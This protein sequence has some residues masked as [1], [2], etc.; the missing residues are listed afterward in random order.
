[1]MRR[2]PAAKLAHCMRNALLALQHRDFVV[3]ACA[4]FCTTLAW[5][6]LSVAVGWQVYR[7]TRNPLDLGLVGLAQFLPFA[8]LVLPAGYVVD[9]RDRRAVLIGAYVMQSLAAGLLLAFS[10]GD[11]RTVTPI[12][13][14]MAL[15]GVARAFS[16]PAAQ[17]VT[18]NLVPAEVFPS[19][20]AC[21]AMLFEV[22]V[23]VGPSLGGVLFLLG[24]PVVYALGFALVVLVGV[25]LA[26]IRPVRPLSPGRVV[27]PSS[28]MEGV[29]FV[30]HRPVVLGAMSLDLFAVLFGGATALLPAFASDILQIG[31]A[32]LGVL[33]T[34]PGA[35][36]VLTAATVALIPIDRHVGRWLFGGIALFAVAT[37]VFGLSRSFWLSVTALVLIGAGDMV[38][39]YVRQLLVQLE[40]PDHIRGRVSA[41]GA[42]F[43]GSSNQLGEFE[44]GLTARYFGV[45]PSVV[46]GGIATLMIVIMYR[47]LFPSL[48]TLDQFRPMP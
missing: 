40:T 41:V 15:F 43:V 47:R 45:V 14:S 3:Y 39:I 8:L 5:E 32:G 16:M 34:A 25:L 26:S 23:I 7:I 4:R 24:A 9:C 2:V 11:T 13:V 33:R 17:A 27:G 22:A 37:I 19:A 1:M 46:L 30:R 12:F 6:M 35:G 10:L 28:L 29:R 18:P 42:M 20:V 31:P 21:S 36:A 38:S 48:R 44:S